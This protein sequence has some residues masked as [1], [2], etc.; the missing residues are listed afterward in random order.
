MSDTSEPPNDI[1]DMSFTVTPSSRATEAKRLHMEKFEKAAESVVKDY[2]KTVE[3]EGTPVSAIFDV[4]VVLQH[5][6]KKQVETIESDVDKTT[7]HGH[8]HGWNAGSMDGYG[9]I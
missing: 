2:G 3:V 6:I 1:E 9:R 4:M 8:Q 7:P 5:M